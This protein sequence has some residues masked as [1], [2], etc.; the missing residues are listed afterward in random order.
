M[1]HLLVSVL[2]PVLALTFTCL[3]ISGQPAVS[4]ENNPADPDSTWLNNFDVSGFEI[5]LEQGKQQLS[6]GE[7]LA[8][9][10]AF[11]QAVQ[12]AKINNG[13]FSKTQI[14][15]LEQQLSV[16]IRQDKWSQFD[17]QI[18]YMEWL[19]GKSGTL[20]ELL[21]GIE[22]LSH[23]HM[24]A[25]AAVTGYE[26]A[27]YLIQA[28]N[29][30]WR[31]VSLIERHRGPHD[32]SLAPWLYQLMLSHF[33][34][35]NLIQRRGLSR[36]DYNSDSH[37]LANGWTF[38][39]NQSL[40]RSYNIGVQLLQRIHRIYTNSDSA[41]P[42]LDA[43]LQIHLADWQMLYGKGATALQYYQQAM[44]NLIQ[45]GVQVSQVNDYFRTPTILPSPNLVVAWQPTDASKSVTETNQFENI[46]FNSWSSSFPGARLPAEYVLSTGDALIQPRVN[47]R[48]SLQTNA[49]NA[50]QF[51]YGIADI[52]FVELV[53]NDEQMLQRAQ[54][55]L[56]GLQLRPVF[57]DGQPSGP[58]QV[59]I[60]YFFAEN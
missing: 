12:I 8:A 48:L 9:E 47:A 14:P 4:Q 20:E 22:K 25:A 46:R 15:A 17:K 13:L 54:F 38:S 24:A 5:L 30:N 40:T 57:I 33:Y 37:H 31:A 11:S 23:W 26:S 53:P 1:R 44:A 59:G 45:N 60:D 55:E 36:S 21:I 2:H 19:Y 6:Y 10:Q 3:T 56:S 50:D 18:D 35:A 16:L 51:Y 39:K 32:L 42:T 28:K 41:P 7:L 29:W 52:E 43:M 58:N 27:W 49:A 34:Q